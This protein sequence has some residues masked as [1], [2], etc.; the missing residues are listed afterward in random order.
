MFGSDGPVAEWRKTRDAIRD[1]ILKNGWSDKRKSFVQSYGDDA[2]DAS[3]LLVPLV[4]FLPPDDP[5]VIGT[6]DAIR[7]DL[8][9]DGLV[10]RYRADKP[11]TAS[12][13][14]KGPSW[15]AVSGWQTLSSMIGRRDE[16]LDLFERLLAMRNDLGLLAEEYD[17]V[18]KP[19]ARQLPAG[20]L[21][22][23]HRQYRQQSA[24][25]GGPAVQRAP[26]HRGGARPR[27]GGN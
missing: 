6:V 14:R 12:P 23:R 20:L 25:G 13:A 8:T 15:S 9:H 26:L 4:G 22:Y 24:L 5:R 19:P 27:N 3:L 21:A 11:V 10:L 1:D 7:R 16:A 18:A 2:L 17:P